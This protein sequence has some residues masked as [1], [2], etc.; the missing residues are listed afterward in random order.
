MPSDDD[1]EDGHD[2][3]MDS[4]EEQEDEDEPCESKT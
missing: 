3:D 4:A 1:A 2:I